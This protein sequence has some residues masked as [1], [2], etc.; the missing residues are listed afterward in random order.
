MA[1]SGLKADSGKLVWLPKSFV[2]KLTKR[3]ENDRP[4]ARRSK[5]IPQGNR[6]AVLQND[7][8][9]SI[10]SEANNISLELKPKVSTIH[11]HFYGFLLGQKTD[12]TNDDDHKNDG[13]DHKNDG[14]LEN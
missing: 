14:G 2:A 3:I 10:H 12:H 4:A 8:A 9:N 11:R 7:F 13:G 6:Y 5:V 1:D